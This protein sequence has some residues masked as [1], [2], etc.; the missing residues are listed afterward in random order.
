MPTVTTSL[1]R[2]LIAGAAGTTA[3]NAA[4]YLDMVLRGRPA[5][6]TPEATVD[7]AADLLHVDIPGDDEQRDARRTALGSLLGSAAGVGASAVLAAVRT[8]GHPRGAAGTLALAWVLAM[9]AGNG[10]MT[11]LGVTDPRTW[12]A[13]DWVADVVPHLAFAVAATATLRS[14]PGEE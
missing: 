1:A 11:A 12:A 2:G 7:R 6:S 9:I 14:W 10:P 8:T 3:L 4:T 5:S 13:K